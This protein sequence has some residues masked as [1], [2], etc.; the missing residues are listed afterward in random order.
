MRSKVMPVIALLIVAAIAAPAAL[1]ENDATGSIGSVQVAN[2]GASP[3]V[4][5]DVA[6]TAAAPS[7]P[8]SVVGSGNNTASNSWGRCRRVAVTAPATRPA[9]CR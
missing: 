7:A 2:T 5:V 3:S 6:N 8:A 9:P 4:G 1:A